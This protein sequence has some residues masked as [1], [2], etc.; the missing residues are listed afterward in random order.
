MT[1]A[2]NKSDTTRTEQFNGWTIEHRYIEPR[3]IKASNGSDTIG[4]D[5]MGLDRTGV[6]IGAGS[7]VPLAVFRRMLEIWDRQ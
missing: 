4:L 1:Y 7:M 3:Y 5:A 2:I 6:S